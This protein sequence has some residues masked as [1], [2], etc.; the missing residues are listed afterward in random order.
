MPNILLSKL[1]TQLLNDNFDIKVNLG[2]FSMWPFLKSNDIAI[3][4]KVNFEDVILGD[5]LVFRANNKILAHRVMSVNIDSVICKGDSCV[6]CDPIVLKNSILG[7]IASI[8]RAGKK[9]DFT[10]KKIQQKNR[11]I[12]KLSPI[13]GYVFAFLRKI[14]FIRK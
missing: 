10:A 14:L 6:S 9:I 1:T 11:I 2:G 8:N 5:V 7:K 4:K 13:I 12:A 3:I